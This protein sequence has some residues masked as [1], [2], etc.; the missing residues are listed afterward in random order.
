[1]IITVYALTL[2]SIH[3]LSCSGSFICL[4]SFLPTQQR[5]GWVFCACLILPFISC[6]GILIDSPTHSLF[7]SVLH[8]SFSEREPARRPETDTMSPLCCLTS[9]HMRTHKAVNQEL[10]CCPLLWNASSVGGS[11]G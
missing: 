6:G 3:S 10:S 11:S 7:C 4:I 2:L 5:Y 8:N 1:M 9:R